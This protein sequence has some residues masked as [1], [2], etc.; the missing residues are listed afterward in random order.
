MFSVICTQELC[1]M[2]GI[3]PGYPQSPKCLLQWDMGHGTW[4]MG[5][6]TWDSTAAQ[7]RQHGHE[8]RPCVSQI[9]PGRMSGE[10]GHEQD[11]SCSWVQ[12]APQN[13][14]WKPSSKPLRETWQVLLA[15]PTT[16]TSKL[17]AQGNPKMQPCLCGQETVQGNAEYIQSFHRGS[18][19]A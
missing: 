7:H 1:S 19:E 12:S 4:N 6:G 2:C 8:L 11:P 15:P 14:S 5:Y 9:T 13:S 17:L 16:G 18:E 3:L 10:G